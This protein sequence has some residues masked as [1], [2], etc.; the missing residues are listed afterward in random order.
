MWRFGSV[1]KFSKP[2]YILEKM[3]RSTT[4]GDILK[5]NSL[6]KISFY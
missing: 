6:R 5:E 3:S 1:A 4:R 2:R